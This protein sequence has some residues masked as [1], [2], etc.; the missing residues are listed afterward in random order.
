[1]RGLKTSEAVQ[2]AAAAGFFSKSRDSS[3]TILESRS[4]FTEQAEI[5]ES[6]FESPTA[7]LRIVR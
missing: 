6:T 1:M 2:G 3:S 4:G 7:I 5:L